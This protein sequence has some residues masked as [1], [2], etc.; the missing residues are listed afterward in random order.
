MST[1]YKVLIGFFIGFA[2]CA[3]LL[4]LEGCDKPITTTLQPAPVIISPIAIKATVDSIQRVDSIKYDAVKKVDSALQVSNKVLKANLVQSRIKE[5]ELATRLKTDTGLNRAN[6]NAYI[7]NTEYGD[8][9]CSTMV[10]NLTDQ[11]SI[12]DSIIEV[13]ESLITSLHESVNI[14]SAQS[15][16]Q[17]NYTKTQDDDIVD[18]NKQLKNKTT[19]S[20][21]I[22]F[23]IPAA[24]ILGLIIKK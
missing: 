9:S 2:A 1:F 13:G 5:T 24:F 10:Q 12:K 8:S 19:I 17:R 20:G 7:D 23:G 18:L 15:E 3:W 4:H 21:L 16:M 14:L 22:K 6:I 11:N